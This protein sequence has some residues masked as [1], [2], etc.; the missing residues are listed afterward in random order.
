MMYLCKIN[1]RGLKRF[2]VYKE[3]MNT[4]CSFNAS[5]RNA[6]GEVIYVPRAAYFEIV[7]QV[8]NNG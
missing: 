5:V 8:G 3:E 1:N 2:N 4:P 6:M 7:I